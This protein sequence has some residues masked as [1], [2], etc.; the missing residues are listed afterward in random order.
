MSVPEVKRVVAVGRPIPATEA[1]P[2]DS[3]ETQMQGAWTDLFNSLKAAGFEKRHLV[4]TTV[5]VTRGG[6]IELYR[7]VRDRMLQGH[8]VASAYLHV[9]RLHTPAHLVEIEGEAEKP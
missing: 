5:S 3:L 2:E 7:Q 8:A 1:A 4:K 9:P 6:Q